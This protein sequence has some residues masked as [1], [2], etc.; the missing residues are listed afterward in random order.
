VADAEYDLKALCELTGVTPRTVHFY[1]QQG[2]I[3]AAGA[4][5]PGARYWRG[6]VSRLRLIRLLQKQHLPLVEIA[7][8]MKAL[9]DSQVDDLIAETTQ[10]KTGRGSALDYIRG[11]LREPAASGSADSGRAAALTRALALGH[12]A[13]ASPGTAPGSPAPSRSQWDRFTFADGIELH[14]QRPLSRLQQR[15]LDRLVA[16]AREIFEEEAP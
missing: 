7:R 11:V 8:R 1:V 12:A 14:V 6:H 13:P 2:L 15:R 3:P 5:G 10:R 4:P 16:A 9:R